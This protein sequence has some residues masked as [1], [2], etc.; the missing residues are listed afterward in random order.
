MVAKYHFC[1][2][3]KNPVLLKRRPQWGEI[4]MEGRA[5][6]SWAELGE[7]ARL[8][9]LPVHRPDAAQGHERMWALGL[10]RPR[11]PLL[12]LPDLAALPAQPAPASPCGHSEHVAGGDTCT[13]AG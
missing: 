11:A 12:L 8:G 5:G 6:L 2:S 10:H 4:R 9:G 3:K 1:I 13:P 7:A